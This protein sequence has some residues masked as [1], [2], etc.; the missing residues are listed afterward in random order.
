ML[1]LLLSHDSALSVYLAL[2]SNYIF[3]AQIA[4][5]DG[6]GDFCRIYVA[7]ALLYVLLVLCHVAP[8]MLGAH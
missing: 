4:R 5:H 6:H 3:A 7:S 8:P 2:A 1:S